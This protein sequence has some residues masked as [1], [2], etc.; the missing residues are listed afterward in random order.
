LF[1][2]VRARPNEQDLLDICA[3]LGVNGTAERAID[4][5]PVGYTTSESAIARPA[6]NAGLNAVE[7]GASRMKMGV[8]VFVMSVSMALTLS[9]IGL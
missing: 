3:I 5:W 7:N 8:A 1:T 4:F 2:G 9:F 6:G